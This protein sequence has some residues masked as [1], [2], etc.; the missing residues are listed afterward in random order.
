MLGLCGLLTFAGRCP[1]GDKVGVH[2]ATSHN[3]GGFNRL[4][5]HLLILPDWEVCD[6]G[7]CTDV[8]YAEAEG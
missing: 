3:N 1:L 5:Q 6:G 7:A 2:L 4:T 8:V